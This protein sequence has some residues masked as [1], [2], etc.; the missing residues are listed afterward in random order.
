MSLITGNTSIDA[1]V[2]SSWNS[3]PGTPASLSFSFLE[4]PPLDASSEDRDGFAPMTDGQRLA[5]HAAL[6]LWASVANLAFTQVGA[7][8]VLQFGTNRQD[9]SSGYAYLPDSFYATT[10]MYLNKSEPYN[11]VF[12]AGSYGPA[13][14]LHEIGHML[15]L[16]HPGDYDSSGD[17]IGGAVLPEEFDNGDYTLM[18]YTE[19]TSTALTGRYAATPM[20]YDVQAIQ[21]LYGANRSYR[22]GDDVYVFGANDAARCI[23][24]AGGNN[25]FDF[26]AIGGKVTIDLREGGFSSTTAGA[27][28]IAVAY[29][30]TIANAIAGSG[31]STIYSSAVGGKITGGAGDDAIVSG[32]GNDI[33]VGG[34]G[35]DTVSFSQDFGSYTVL[36]TGYGVIVTGQ[37]I[38]RLEGVETLVFSDRTLQ[39]SALALQGA[40]G[41][42][43]N[44]RLQLAP[45][46]EFID[47]GAGL[48]IVTVGGARAHYA[49]ELA[50]G[51][52]QLTDLFGNG[53]TDHLV[54]VERLFFSDRA[55]SFEASDAPGQLYRLY[56]AAFN[57]EPDMPGLGFWINAME[58]G[59]TLEGVANA[60]VQ[61]P[62][63]TRAHG[64]INNRDF[65]T[66]MYRN[67]LQREPD[68]DGLDW[69]TARLGEG[70]SRSDVL[71]SFSESAEGQAQVVGTISQGIEYIVFGSA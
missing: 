25:T 65:A 40:G 58:R 5:V 69:Y 62:E 23:W 43:G 49:L 64:S 13:V 20:L 37:G 59:A 71:R 57:R 41:T 7:D 68:P 63:F 8:G 18:S 11:S 9:N 39:V 34:E 27:H 24:D 21:H 50:N 35:A 61:S 4:T 19:P 2:Y 15:G 17:A 16:K 26:S 31:G 56:Q 66:L 32:A 52:H 22:T 55:V 12:A 70:A 53:G 38:D 30:V 44:D 1:L 51:L 10:Q 14:I 47:G 42:A 36:R 48:D 67:A 6:E 60:F 29:G 33:V 46:D 54:N 28:N 45:G 3:A